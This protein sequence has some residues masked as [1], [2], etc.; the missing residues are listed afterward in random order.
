MC[1]SESEVVERNEDWDLTD[2]T[3]IS[4]LLLEQIYNDVEL[5]IRLCYLMSATCG[6]L[7]N[8]LHPRAPTTGESSQPLD[9]PMV[10]D[11]AAHSSS[12]QH[13]FSGHVSSGQLSPLTKW[14]LFAHGPKSIDMQRSFW[15]FGRKRPDS[16][17]VWQVHSVSPLGDQSKATLCQLSPVSMTERRPACARQPGLLTETPIPQF[18]E[19]NNS[20]Q[21]EAQPDAWAVVASSAAVKALVKVLK[22]MVASCGTSA[23]FEL[24]TIFACP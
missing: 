12:F 24:W 5:S 8:G 10:Y 19:Q 22:C 14:K 23:C 7:P 17:W 2:A 4:L 15:R 3:Y 21:K 20:S 13:A 11:F 9:T 18:S 6:K 16:Q 1:Q